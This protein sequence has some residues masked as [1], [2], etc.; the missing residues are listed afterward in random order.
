MS[1]GKIN[2]RDASGSIGAVGRLDPAVGM[3][4][5]NGLKINRVNNDGTIIVSGNTLVGGSGQSVRSDEVFVSTVMAGLFGGTWPT[6]PDVIRYNFSQK[7][8]TYPS[9]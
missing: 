6:G 1:I 7:T 3:S 4:T 8:K 2:V 5:I 9:H